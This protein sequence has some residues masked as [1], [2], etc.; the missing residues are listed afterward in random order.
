[1]RIL[2]SSASIVADDSKEGKKSKEF[3]EDFFGVDWN[4]KP[5]KIIK[6]ENNTVGE[7]PPSEKKLPIRP[8]KEVALKYSATKEDIL[9]PDF[10]SSK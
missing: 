5:F 6:G 3:L 9:N 1:M 7:L 2:A 10:D 4:E 8:F